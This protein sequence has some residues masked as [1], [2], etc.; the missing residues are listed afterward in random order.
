M[1][2]T[3]NTSKAEET[4]KKTK[5][6]FQNVSGGVK[7][8]AAHELV[9]SPITS[10]DL[11]VD[12]DLDKV[13]S[14][15]AFESIAQVQKT[16][17]DYNDMYVGAFKQIAEVR[18]LF[19]EAYVVPINKLYED[20]RKIAAFQN[21]VAR[22]IN[23]FHQNVSEVVLNSGITQVA[24][25]LR[26]IRVEAFTGLYI[27]S[28]FQNE[29]ETEQNGIVEVSKIKQSKLLTGGQVQV[30]FEKN[31]RTLAKAEVAFQK[32]DQIETRIDFVAKDLSTTKAD[33]QA[34][35]K[36]MEDERGLLQILQNNP[37]PYFKIVSIEFQ[38]KKSLFTVN[39]EILIPIPQYSLM[40]NLCTVLFSGRQELGEEW[41]EDS[42]QEAWADFVDH[43][44]ADSISWKKILTIVDHLNTLFAKNTTKDDLV[45]IERP[46]RLRLNPQY[47]L[48]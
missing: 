3:K 31:T 14:S 46:K 19:D 40:E 33:A 42:I 16:I 8:R 30:D 48:G 26:S 29:Y 28:E 17:R 27:T 38:P 44:Q 15:P 36:M 41:Y 47:F 11:V 35:R 24:N 13:I 34:I 21:E 32:V 45:I 18:S 9:Y 6:T 1:D 2:K 43:E 37:F 12:L 23:S 5:K 20:I 4:L 7:K 22:S 39:N 25:M 10:K